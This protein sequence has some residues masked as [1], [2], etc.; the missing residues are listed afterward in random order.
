MRARVLLKIVWRIVLD[1]SLIW[2]IYPRFI[3]FVGCMKTV[4]SRSTDFR[5][6]HGKENNAHAHAVEA[7]ISRN[8]AFIIT[9]NTQKAM[10]LA[11]AT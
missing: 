1:V 2:M 10:I 4:I 5:E 3:C 11:H 8:V 6:V 9:K 7:R